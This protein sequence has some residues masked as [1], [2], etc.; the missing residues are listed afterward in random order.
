MP[1]RSFAQLSLLCFLLA[2]EYVSSLLLYHPPTSLP[3]QTRPRIQIVRQVYE[4]IFQRLGPSLLVEELY[5]YSVGLYPLFNFA[6]IVVKEA[7]LSLYEK[8]FVPLGE[9]LVPTL[10]PFILAVLPGLEEGSEYFSR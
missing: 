3:A 5:L 8:Y 10:K 6:A 9:A 1:P 4:L 7:L 2:H